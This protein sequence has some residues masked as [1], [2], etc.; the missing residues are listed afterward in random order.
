[1]ENQ[2]TTTLYLT[3]EESDLRNARTLLAGMPIG[4][5]GNIELRDLAEKLNPDFR[6]EGHIVANQ[7]RFG[8]DYIGLDTETPNQPPLEILDALCRKFPSLRYYY[9]VQ[10]ADKHITNDREQKFFILPKISVD[11]FH[12]DQELYCEFDISDQAFA[13]LSELL[14]Q[15]FHTE[16]EVNQF[17]EAQRD[18][19]TLNFCR[20]IHTE[21][22]D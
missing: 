8:A 14:H 5:D 20:I 1:M 18:G 16:E 9:L 13:W 12:K 4:E 22:V 2:L 7:L 21:M 10:L 3:G 19:E 17:L 11:L 6:C 15:D